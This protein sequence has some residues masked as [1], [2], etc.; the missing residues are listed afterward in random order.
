MSGETL[1]A[2]SSQKKDVHSKPIKITVEDIRKEYELA[3]IDHLTNANDYVKWL[4]E[5]LAQYMTLCKRLI[6]W[7]SINNT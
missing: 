7:E 2:L 5:N 3:T 6:P 4:E 1:I